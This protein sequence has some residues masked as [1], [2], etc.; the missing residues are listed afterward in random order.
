MSEIKP[1]DLIDQS[2]NS[3]VKNALNKAMS[4]YLTR[5][6]TQMVEEGLEASFQMHLAGL[7]RDELE[8][9][10]IA[11]DERFIVELEKNMG[12]EKKNYVDI[13]IEFYEKGKPCKQYLIELKFKKASQTA[14]NQNVINSFIDIYNLE[15]LAIHNEKIEACYFIFLTDYERYTKETDKGTR[16][17]FTMHN[18]AKIQTNKIYI[19][20]SKTAKK[21]LEKYKNGLKF[22][23]NYQIEYKKIETHDKSYWFF[24]LEIKTRLD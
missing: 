15:Q 2:P 6:K 24:L 12:D 8:L 21:S 4:I 10:T 13:S 18:G 22:S 17:I 9:L 20:E 16:Q 7:L 14:G 1:A 23:N 19:D 3:R 5:L 11:R